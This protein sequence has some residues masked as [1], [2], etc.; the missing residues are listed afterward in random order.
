MNRKQKKERLKNLKEEKKTVEARLIEKER[1]RALWEQE[2]ARLKAEAE[3]IK[4]ER[5]VRDRHRYEV[6]RAWDA[7]CRERRA[8]LNNTPKTSLGEW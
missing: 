6:K 1:Q 8:R 7:R 5:E 3:R 2:Q 4:L